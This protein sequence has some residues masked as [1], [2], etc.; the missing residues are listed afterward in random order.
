MT[1]TLLN[2]TGEHEVVAR[3]KA[4]NRAVCT[5]HAISKLAVS[6]Q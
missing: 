2:P 3:K 1:R 6:R 5:I 4:A